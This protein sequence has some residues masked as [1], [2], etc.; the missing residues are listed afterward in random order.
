M[1][2][3]LFPY[4]LG[5]LNNMCSHGRRPVSEERRKQQLLM[6]HDKRF[7]VDLS[8]TAVNTTLGILLGSQKLVRQRGA[9]GTNKLIQKAS[10][11][12]KLVIEITN[13]SGGYLPSQETKRLRWLGQAYRCGFIYYWGGRD[14]RRGQVRKCAVHV[15]CGAVS[16]DGSA[17]CAQRT[18]GVTN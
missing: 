4:G 6:Y 11:E 10:Q 16:R 9:C 12:T 5:G 17:P 15:R 8:W 1:F 2:P 3:W 13:T 18:K 14:I 7:Q